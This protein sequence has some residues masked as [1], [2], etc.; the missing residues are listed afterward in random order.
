MKSAFR[1]CE[2]L[3][4][5]PKFHIEAPS[6]SEEERVSSD[7]RSLVLEEMCEAHLNAV[8]KIEEV[9][10]SNPWRRKDF[11]Y[12]LT[13]EGSYGTVLLADGRLIGYTIGFFTLEE[14]HLADFAIHPDL[15]NR[16]IGRQLLK[17]LLDRLRQRPVN[18]VSLEVRASNTTAVELYK[19]ANFQTVAIRRGYYSRPREDA[20]VML[21]VLRGKLSDWMEGAITPLL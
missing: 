9:V 13:R 7:V 12:S 1:N 18:L 15:Q 2:N 10:F 4:T 16:G 5:L 21:K 6:W 11:Q 8:L 3:R 19:K 14:F 20:L 17:L